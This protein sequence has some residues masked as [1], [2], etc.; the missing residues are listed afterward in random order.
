MLGFGGGGSL[1]STLG[2]RWHIYI[3]AYDLDVRTNGIYAYIY[4]ILVSNSQI[5]AAFCKSQNAWEQ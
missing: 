2:F 4:T 1:G 5:S 3:F